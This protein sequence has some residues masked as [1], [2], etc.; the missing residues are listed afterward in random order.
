MLEGR[1]AI[2]AEAGHSKY[3]KLDREHLSLFA[4]RVVARGVMNRCHGAVWKGL[5][6]EP[7]GSLCSAVVPKTNH[8]FGH[9]L[10][11]FVRQRATPLAYNETA[12]RESTVGLNDALRNEA[13][14]LCNLYNTFMRSNSFHGLMRAATAT[15]TAT[16]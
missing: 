1:A 12:T 8:V 14:F 6:V 11:P 5:S 2:E 15:A 9:R 16:A 13:G 3:R 10:S 7:G 4:G